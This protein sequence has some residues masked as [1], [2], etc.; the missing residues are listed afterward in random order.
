MGQQE[1]ICVVGGGA[2]GISAASM[3]KRTNPDATVIICTEFDGFAM[4]NSV[5]GIV[6]PAVMPS[7]HEMPRVSICA[8]GTRTL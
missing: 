3:A 8:D 6:R 2:A 5:I 4:K 1:T 7:A